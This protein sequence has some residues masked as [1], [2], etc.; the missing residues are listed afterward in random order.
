[1]PCTPA[2]PLICTINQFAYSPSRPTLTTL[3]L[4]QS[5]RFGQQ[6]FPLK[7]PV[8]GDGDSDSYLTDY[9]KLG[10]AIGQS[11]VEVEKNL[12]TKGVAVDWDTKA[13]NYM[14]K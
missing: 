9:L 2:I 6:T 1:M 10:R 3:A 14:Q 8:T 13:L 12:K 7:T 4:L 5:K 11:P